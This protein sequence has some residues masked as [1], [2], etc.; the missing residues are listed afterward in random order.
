MTTQNVIAFRT[1]LQAAIFQEVL[2][3]ELTKGHWANATPRNH[4]DP[5]KDAEVIVDEKKVGVGFEPIKANYDLLNKD[6]VDGID[7]KKLKKLQ[8]QVGVSDLSRK[9]LRREL[10]EMMFIMRTPIG[11]PLATSNQG[12]IGRPGRP[13]REMLEALKQPKPAAPSKSRRNTK[14]N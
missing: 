12:L 5:W 9:E 8:K 3:P 10:R 2:V 14:A 4:A 11:K 1:P 6:M 13:S 7:E